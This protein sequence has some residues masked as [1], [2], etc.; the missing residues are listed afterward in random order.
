VQELFDGVL[1]LTF[2]LP[3]GIDHVHCY[4]L[5]ASDGSWTLVDT[6]LGADDPEA[7]WRSV[8]AELDAPVGRI[9]ITHMHPDHVGGAR[10]AAEVTGAPVLQG[11]ED[12]EQCLRAWGPERSPERLAEFMVAHGMPRSYVEGAML[13]SAALAARVHAVERPALLEPGDE[14][15]GWRVELLRGHADGHLVL[16]RDGVMIAGDTI[17]GHITPAIGLY[18]AARPDPLGDYL[19]TL[20]RIEEM[21]PRLALPGH[22]STIEDPP[23]RAREIAVHHDRRLEATEAALGREPLNAY[24][25]SLALFQDDLSPT[26]RRFALAE[27]L[28]HLERLVRDGHA[29]RVDEAGYAAA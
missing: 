28:A 15:D 8:L 24:E 19:E 6:G 9:V 2:R 10:D 13:E 17:L 4:L 12:H 16:L 25:V 29:R 14:V 5:R 23:A 21:A 11:R 20:R 1:R 7:V 26:L 27:S 3:L 18:P 22:G